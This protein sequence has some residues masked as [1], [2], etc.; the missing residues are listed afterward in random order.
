MVDP[1]E[2]EESRLSKLGITC[3]SIPGNKEEYPSIITS[4]LQEIVQYVD[5]QKKQSETPELTK[6]INS[7]VIGDTVLQN[8]R[9]PAL[10]KCL[11]EFVKEA[12]TTISNALIWI[13]EARKTQLKE[14]SKLYYPADLQFESQFMLQDTVEFFVSGNQPIFESLPSYR[15]CV[16]MMN[17]DMLISGQVNKRHYMLGISDLLSNWTYISHILKKIILNYIVTGSLEINYFIKMYSDLELFFSNEKLSILEL[18]P[19]YNLSI[20]GSDSID[21]GNRL[22]IRKVTDR[23]KLLFHKL[24]PNAGSTLYKL[25]HVKYVIEYKLTRRKGFEKED[26]REYPANISSVFSS[27][28]AALRLFQ[29]KPV[30]ISSQYKIVETDIPIFFYTLHLYALNLEI[31]LGEY[32]ILE[33]GQVSEFKQ[34]WNKY[35]ETLISK[36]LNYKRYDNDE[37]INIK[38]AMEY[39]L[40]GFSMRDGND[41]FD[42]FMKS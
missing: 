32:Y 25:A 14:Y 36:V 26:I 11:F 37:F 35:G 38:N 41:I 28:I 1:S 29:T 21:L 42:E 39:F 31:G 2:E 18:S 12:I 13:Q 33:E 22:S 24:S 8:L 34:F 9:N 23:E 3:I 27:V 40:W 19:I 5:E 17:Q 7:F 30:G 10:C 16:N 15:K 4:I 20:I 6:D